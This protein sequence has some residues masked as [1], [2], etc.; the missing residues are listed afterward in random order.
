LINRLKK[1]LSKRK[2]KVFLLFFLCSSLA[3]FISNLSDTYASNTTFDL[4]FENVPD[5]L[6]LTNVS[7]KEIDVKIDATGFQ[8]LWFNFK[9]KSVNID[10]AS[11]EH[12]GAKYYVPQRIYRRQIN[13]QIGGMSL[14]D[15]EKDTLFFDFLRVYEKRVPVV[16]KAEIQLEPN[17]LL[18][19]GIQLNP[20][21]ITVVG[22][23]K[24]IDTIRFLN[25]LKMVLPEINKDFSKNIGLEKPERLTFSKFSDQT[26]SLTGKVFRFSEQ[27]ITVPVRVR[28]L[29]ENVSITTFPSTVAIVC[30][31]K[32]SVLKNLK[33]E[34]F[35]LVADYA[36][37]KNQAGN[38]LALELRKKPKGLFT[39]RPEIMQV[40]YILKRE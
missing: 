4:V 10:V 19:N 33:T 17:Y 18:E 8:F 34:D 40:E 32:I 39:A 11:M 14:K 22:P 3:W 24:E 5:S 13:R 30:K 38:T 21:S 1:S 31:A 25:T 2:V 35:D 7:Q 12:K 6:V 23:K 27:V 26:V 15:I 36:A 9:P 29:P 20:D 16:S 28:N 37:N